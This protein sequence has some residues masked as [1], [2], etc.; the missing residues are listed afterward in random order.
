MSDYSNCK[1]DD[2]WWPQD[3]EQA[4]VCFWFSFQTI[5]KEHFPNIR[6]RRPCNDTCGECAVFRNALRYHESC[7]KQ[8]EDSDHYRE[9]GSISCYEMAKLDF[10]DD[11][12]MG[13]FAKLFL[14]RDCLEQESILEAVGN[15]VMQAKGM[16]R[17]V[18]HSTESS[19]ACRS[20]EVTH[21]ERE[22]ELVCDYSQIMPLPYYVSNQK[23]EIYYFNPLTINLFDMVD[24]SVTPNKLK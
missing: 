10:K 23:G 15:H 1:A 9:D 20:T 6:I 3:T 16:R 22:H 21:K 17:R 19:I 18:Q 24:L 4:E 7:R 12:L 14:T 8:D 13:E 5:W 2:M 11:G